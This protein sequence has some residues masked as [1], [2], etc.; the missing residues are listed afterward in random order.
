MRLKSESSVM[1]MENNEA[2]TNRPGMEALLEP[3]ME[4][5]LGGDCREPGGAPRDRPPK[6]DVT[7][8]SRPKICGMVAI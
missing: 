7:K 1:L 4:C 3:K 8:V 6:I 5:A 2:K